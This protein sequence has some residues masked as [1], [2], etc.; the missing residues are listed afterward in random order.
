MCCACHGTASDC[1]ITLGK[2][3]RTLSRAMKS[4]STGRGRAALHALL[5]L[6]RMKGRSV[7]GG[8]VQCR[9]RAPHGRDGCCTPAKQQVKR[10]AAAVKAYRRKRLNAY[11]APTESGKRI[12]WILGGLL[13]LVIVTC[14]GVLIATTEPPVDQPTYVAATT[15]TPAVDRFTVSPTLPQASLGVSRINVYNRLVSTRNAHVRSVRESYAHRTGRCRIARGWPDGGGRSCFV[16]VRWIA[17]GGVG[18][19]SDNRRR[20]G[21]PDLPDASSPVPRFPQLSPLGERRTPGY[22][23]GRQL[24]LWDADDPGGS[25]A[26]EADQRGSRADSLRAGS[27][28]RRIGGLCDKGCT[29]F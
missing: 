20:S 28:R 10:L 2:S 24:A 1:V 11:P 14:T 22:C 27:V 7:I 29:K 17:G 9:L 8:P 15:P 21:H 5:W 26:L 18:Y 6:A 23:H 25:R 16:K 3:P 19:G 4:E 13:V 12:A